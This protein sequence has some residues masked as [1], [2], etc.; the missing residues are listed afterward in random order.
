MLIIVHKRLGSIPRHNV[1][2]VINCAQ[3]HMVKENFLVDDG[4]LRG[5]LWKSYMQKLRSTS[6]CNWNGTAFWID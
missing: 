4:S 1:H 6:S 2:G 3:K 5:F